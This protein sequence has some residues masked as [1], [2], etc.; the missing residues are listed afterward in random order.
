M[1]TIFRTVK[2]G[3]RKTQD[4]SKLRKDIRVGSARIN[5]IKDAHK[6]L[7]YFDL[8]AN[9]KGLNNADMFVELMTNYSRTTKTKVKRFKRR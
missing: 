5:S 4:V 1:A 7:R 9:Q 6:A 3:K 2:L 8:I